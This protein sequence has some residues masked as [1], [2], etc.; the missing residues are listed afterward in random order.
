MTREDLSNFG[1]PDLSALLKS[2]DTRDP[3]VTSAWTTI[4][5]HDNTTIG[6]GGALN[7]P[8][9]DKATHGTEYA[10]FPVDAVNGKGYRFLRYRIFFQLDQTQGYADPLPFVDFICLRYQFNL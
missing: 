4:K 1:K 2:Q 5:V 8:G 3:S 7:V 6:G 9:Y 10:G